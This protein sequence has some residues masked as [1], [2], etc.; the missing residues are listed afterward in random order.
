M[1]NSQ[2]AG[3]KFW[4]G[5]TESS[6]DAPELWEMKVSFLVVLPVIV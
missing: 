4:G 3:L 5:K 6:E 1:N 2:Q